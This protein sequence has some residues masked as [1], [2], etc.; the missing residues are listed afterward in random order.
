MKYTRIYHMLVCH[1]HTPEMAGR[2][3]L[4]GKRHDKWSVR[5]IRR[6]RNSVPTKLWQERKKRLT[7]K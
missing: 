5:W 7:E 3:I 2:I 1:G 4:E 6:S